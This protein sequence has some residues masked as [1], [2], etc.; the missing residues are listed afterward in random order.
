MI[1]YFSLFGERDSKV[2][3]LIYS[4][5]LIFAL[6]LELTLL[7]NE[8]ATLAKIC[9]GTCKPCPGSANVNSLT[10]L[11]MVPCVIEAN[12]APTGYAMDCSAIGACGE[13]SELGCV[14]S[15]NAST[16]ACLTLDEMNADSA[17]ILTVINWS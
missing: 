13:W 3:K 16:T 4:L 15:A 12:D 11:G 10:E 7:L 9:L 2:P 17:V 6:I 8:T 1:E 14:L 5:D